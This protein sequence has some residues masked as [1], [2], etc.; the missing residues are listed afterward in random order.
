MRVIRYTKERR[1]SRRKALIIYLF[2]GTLLV[3]AYILTKS[4]FTKPVSQEIL[5][6][7]HLQAE[8]TPFPTPIPIIEDEVTGS[9]LLGETIS[10]AL[11][12]THGTYGIVVKNLETG[13][14][15]SL[16]EHAKFYSASLYKLWIM[17]TAYKQIKDDKLKENDVLQSTIPALNEKYNIPPES[18]E[19][20]EGDIKLTVKDAL[21]KMITVS[22][23]YAALLLT[24]KVK[25]SNASSFLDRNG[26][27]ES[28]L[29]SSAKEGVP[30]TTPHDI[31]LF[32]EKL[33]KKQLVNESYSDKMIQLLKSQRLN[34]KL[35]K[36]LP[37]NIVVAHKTGE[38]DE[39]THDAGIVYAQNG[40][41]IIVVLSKSNDP[42]LA[43][44]RISNISQ[45]VF[46]Y[47][48]NK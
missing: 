20:K 37:D 45:A 43:E 8:T 12:G 4:V 41:Y 23:N 44:D 6:E 47:F 38:L 29:G 28:V 9:E 15:Y 40:D 1:R 33:Y 42:P 11:T 39:F 32:F 48:Q 5:G 16:N 30:T 19:L 46:N 18:A 34:E 3:I 2:F 36:L 13:E 17:G 26:F 10:D 21:S 14:S 27:R 31:A 24:E 25:L 35:P 22:D 7:E